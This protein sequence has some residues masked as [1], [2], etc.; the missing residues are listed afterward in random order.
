M[1]SQKKSRIPFV[2]LRAQH[3][4]LRPELEEA[5]PSLIKNCNFILGQPVEEFE[6]KFAEFVGVK[7]AIGVANGLEA[8]RL[9][10]QAIGIGAGDEVVLPANTYIATALAVSQV[11]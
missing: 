11:G 9:S 1:S 6:R 4:A 2:D 7:H 3:S 5:F 10:L 8:L